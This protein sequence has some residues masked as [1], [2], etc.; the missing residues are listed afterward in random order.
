[1]DFMARKI[2]TST[3][4]ARATCRRARA[5]AREEWGGGVGVELLFPR[6]WATRTFAPESC[7]QATI[8]TI[9]I[10]ISDDQRS[11]FS[12]TTHHCCPF[13]YVNVQ[14]ARAAVSDVCVCRQRERHLRRPRMHAAL[15]TFAVY[16]RPRPRPT[17]P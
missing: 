2:R 5:R 13:R 1:M 9:R 16:A 3:T 12:N 4:R 7:V 6:V 17:P 14:C 11:V 8:S 15:A 10:A